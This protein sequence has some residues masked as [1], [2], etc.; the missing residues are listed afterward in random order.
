MKRNGTDV[1]HIE[2]IEN[3]KAIRSQ[4]SDDINNYN[5]E[6]VTKYLEDN[7]GI[8]TIKRKKCLDVG[9]YMYRNR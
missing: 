9:M 8:K 2:Y 4:I 6:Q 3:R 7:K 5:E 1:Q